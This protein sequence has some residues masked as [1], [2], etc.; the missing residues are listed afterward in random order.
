MKP[1]PLTVIV[2]TYNE[3]ANI[4]PVISRIDKAVHPQEI[5]VV[6]DSSP[7]GT[8]QRVSRYRLHHANVRCIINTPRLGL[9]ASIQKGIDAARSRYIAW[10]DADFSHPPELLPDMF[11][12]MKTA[13]I[14]VASWLTDGGRDDRRESVQNMFSLGINRLCQ[15]VFGHHI[16]TYSSGYFMTRSSILNMLP[17]EGKYGEYC[18]YFLVRA[19]RKKLNIAEVPFVCVS[20]SSGKTKTSPDPLTYIGNGCRYLM[21]IL[22]LVIKYSVD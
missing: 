6:D 19:K 22:Q 5:I 17:I 21:A 16:H 14:V 4:I 9:A 13:D 20:R 11:T 3:L 8:G 10:L 2:P 7:D 15:T 12:Q 18:I 1:T